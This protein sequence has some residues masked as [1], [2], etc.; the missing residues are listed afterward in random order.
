MDYTT[1]QGLFVALQDVL[2]T[3]LWLISSSI[4]VE[5]TLGFIP[6]QVILVGDSAGGSLHL[7]LTLLIA[8][9]NKLMMY[10]EEDPELLTLPAGFLAVYTGFRTPGTSASRML[11]SMIDPI[12]STGVILA[13]GEQTD[14]EFDYTLSAHAPGRLAFLSDLLPNFLSS[15]YSLLAKD[16]GIISKAMKGLRGVPWYRKSNFQIKRRMFEIQQMFNRSPYLVMNHLHNQRSSSQCENVE[17]L[18]SGSCAGNDCDFCS[19]QNVPIHLLTTHF[20]PMLDDNV[21]LAN[22]WQGPVQ[23]S[24]LEDLPHGFLNFTLT[25]IQAQKGSDICVNILNNFI[26][27]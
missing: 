3:Y 27:Q 15:A 11:M 5:I 7:T 9:I 17:T 4:D 12:L 16:L 23:L 20:D 14:E 18:G 22:L 2:D 8:D 1:G 25:S 10:Q 19:V 26:K 13:T 21:T 6:K 24:V